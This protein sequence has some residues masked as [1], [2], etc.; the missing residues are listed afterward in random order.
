MASFKKNSVCGNILSANVLKIKLWSFIMVHILQ[1]PGKFPATRN[2]YQINISQKNTCTS[3]ITQK[4]K[5]N[6]KW[7][8]LPIYLLIY[9]AAIP[10]IH[11]FQTFCKLTSDSHFIK[12]SHC[13]S[14]LIARNLIYTIPIKRLLNKRLVLSL[15]QYKQIQPNLY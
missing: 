13:R 8:S 2:M 1:D 11:K 10:I 5:T 6:F 9:N 14:S 7:K 4:S 15:Q 3:G 12:R